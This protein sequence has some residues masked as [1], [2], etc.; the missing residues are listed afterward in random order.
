MNFAPLIPCAANRIFGCVGKIAPGGDPYCHPC[1]RRI[2]RGEG[3]KFGVPPSS[4][5][6]L[7]ASVVASK[8]S[9]A[10]N[11]AHRTGPPRFPGG[12]ARP[13]G[14]TTSTERTDRMTDI[15][16][17]MAAKAAQVADLLDTTD[18]NGHTR[19]SPEPP[20]PTP[21]TDE[22]IGGG[23]GGARTPAPVPTAEQRLAEAERTGDTATSM[24]LKSQ[25]LA[26]IM[27]GN[28]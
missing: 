9:A 15:N 7:P 20:A 21:A 26:G 12:R 17:G 16:E 27:A 1:F 18:V 14:P 28:N 19:P 4:L 11:G 13:S 8:G 22:P 10:E 24:S 6:T 5:T 2:E 23:D 25:H 3:I